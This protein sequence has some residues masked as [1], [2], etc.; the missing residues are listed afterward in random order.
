M[1]KKL[2]TWQLLGF[3]TVCLLGTLLHFVYRWSGE[4]PA[5]AA[6]SAVNESTWEHMKMLYIPY[7]L[8]VAV[9]CFPIARETDNFFAA[10]AAGALAG[11]LT[12][13]SLFYLLRG[14]FGRTGLW[15]HAGI[16]LVSA[17]V[18]FLVGG[19]VLRRGKL[20][21]GLLQI[22]GFLL[23]WALLFCFVW[24]TWHTPTVPLFLDP[25]CGGFGVAS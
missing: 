21:G 22:G 16:F 8:Y 6:F 23:L 25:V 3:G 12:L 13:P 24:F 10:A 2:T 1:R 14:V 20:R 9:S 18:L 5:A 11:L 4:N 19:A 7:F 17:A 15:V